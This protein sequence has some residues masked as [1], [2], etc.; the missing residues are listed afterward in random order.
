MLTDANKNNKSVCAV[1]CCGN[2]HQKVEGQISKN[3]STYFTYKKY[4][5]HLSRF[6]F[7]LLGFTSE[8][9]DL[10]IIEK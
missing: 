10:E 6:A 2:S 7:F 1:L 9:V 4:L 3:I 5:F 8:N